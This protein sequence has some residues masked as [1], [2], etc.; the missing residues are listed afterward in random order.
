MV[1]VQVGEKN[2]HDLCG[3]AGEEGYHLK[4]GE[5]LLRSGR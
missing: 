5:Q 1:E 2:G 3:Q 4:S